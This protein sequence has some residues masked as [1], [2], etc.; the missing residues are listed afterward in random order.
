LSSSAA[1]CSK[2]YISQHHINILLCFEKEN[3]LPQF[4]PV[5]KVLNF[6][7]VQSIAQFKRIFVTSLEW[8]D[9]PTFLITF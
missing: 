5:L 2:K 8:V 4:F 6:V 9:F 7:A 3:S 1:G